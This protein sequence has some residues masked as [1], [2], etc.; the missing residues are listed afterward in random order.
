[1]K[2]ATLHGLGN[3]FLADAVM[4]LFDNDLPGHAAGY[5]F[6]HVRNENARAPKSWLTMANLRVGDDIPPKEPGGF[7]LFCHAFPFQYGLY[8]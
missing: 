8:H 3:R 1:M 4:P 2:E 5:L 6:Q 7:V